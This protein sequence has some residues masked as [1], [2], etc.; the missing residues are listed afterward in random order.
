LHEIPS[1]ARKR[2][3]WIRKTAT[4]DCKPLYGRSLH[5][6]IADRGKSIGLD[7]SPEAVGAL[8]ASI[9]NSL[10]DIANELQKLETVS[11]SRRIQAS[12]VYGVVGDFRARTLFELCD[13]AGEMKPGDAVG[14]LRRMMLGKINEGQ[15]LRMLYNHFVTL[16]VM[17]EMLSEGANLEK[18]SKKVGKHVFILKGLIPQARLMSAERFAK[19]MEILFAADYERKSGRWSSP[20]DLE[21]YLLQACRA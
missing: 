12:E 13:A 6:W 9:G 14:V 7:L 21:V 8:E 15:I 17:N 19:L 4:I 2:N 16:H 1:D 11:G 3:S 10:G 5:R 18:I 20:R